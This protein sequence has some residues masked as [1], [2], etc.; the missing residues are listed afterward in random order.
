LAGDEVLKSTARVI[1]EAVRELDLVARLGGEEI[2][3]ALPETG[4]PEARVVAERIRARVQANTI[5]VGPARLSVTVSIGLA[6]VPDPRVVGDDD[7]IRLADQALYAAKRAG[8][9]C[10]RSSDD[11]D[12]LRTLEIPS[13]PGPSGSG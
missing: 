11:P 6:T 9:N 3:V 4:P 5:A 1:L 13:V 7:L 8:R 10:V 12:P 2:A